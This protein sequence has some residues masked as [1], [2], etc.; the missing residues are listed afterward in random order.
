M[1]LRSQLIYACVCIHVCVPEWEVSGLVICRILWSEHWTSFSRIIWLFCWWFMKLVWWCDAHVPCWCHGD[2]WYAEALQ[3]NPIAPFGPLW[4]VSGSVKLG[5]KT[6]LCQILSVAPTLF[7]PLAPVKHCC[8]LQ[9]VIT[10]RVLHSRINE[11]WSC[12]FHAQKPG[13]AAV[14][15]PGWIYNCTP[16][17]NTLLCSGHTEQPVYDMWL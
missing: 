3:G 6:G 12:T 1:L 4:H 9:T 2:Y 5:G 7:E 17:S 14:L 8:K 16:L 13:D 11:C 10:V 15:V